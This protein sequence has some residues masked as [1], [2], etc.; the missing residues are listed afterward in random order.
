MSASNSSSQLPACGDD[1]AAYALRA[2]DAVE[3]E[4]FQVHLEACAVCRDELAAFKY[5]L[6]GLPLSVAHHAAPGP[7]RRR[8]LDAVEREATS[9]PHRRRRRL[10]LPFGANRWSPR[11]ALALGAVCIAAAAIVGLQLGSS[12]PLETHVYAAQVTGLGTAEVKV[13]G[14]R[15][16]LIVHRF[17]PP[18]A[19]EIYQIWLGRPGHAPIPTSALFSVTAS[20]D[21]D[22][23]VPGDLHRITSLMVTPEPAGGTR[24]P[25]H[26]AVIRAQLT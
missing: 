8:V 20:G 11:T 7:L 18:P 4:R 2:L 10:R 12:S 1:V 5:A 13:T 14:R 9:A 16:E 21:G 19:G 22:V 17:S 25:T 23:E 26:P 24:T 3:A 6:D 15:G